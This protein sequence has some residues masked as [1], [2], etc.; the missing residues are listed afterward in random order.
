MTLEHN[1][2][3]GR[4][5]IYTW[6]WNLNMKREREKSNKR[7]SIV[8]IPYRRERDVNVKREFWHVTVLASLKPIA[9]CS[10]ISRSRSAFTGEEQK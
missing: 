9:A 2:Y 5:S 1:S 4:Y 6:T 8:C 3:L 10:D 7:F